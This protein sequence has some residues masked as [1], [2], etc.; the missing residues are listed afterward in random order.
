MSPGQTI[1]SNEILFVAAGGLLMLD[2]QGQVSGHISGFGASD[3]VSFIDEQVTGINYDSGTGVL[4]LHLHSLDDLG[5][6]DLSLTFDGMSGGTFTAQF[7]GLDSLL[8][9]NPIQWPVTGGN[10]AGQWNNPKS[11]DWGVG[12]WGDN[13]VPNFLDDITLNPPVGHTVTFNGAIDGQ[14]G[15]ASASSLTVAAGVTFDLTHH[16]SLFFSADLHNDGFID[17]LNS[18]LSFGGVGV[19][20]GTIIVHGT[21]GFIS[22]TLDIDKARLTTAVPSSLGHMAKR[23]SA[24]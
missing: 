12:N 14:A 20:T 23:A 7:D 8:Y 9:F 16:G 4:Q 2:G 18:G 17:V 13:D 15:F 21:S 22:S 10:G 19:N 24:R 11:G 1:D 5:D 3:N 6:H